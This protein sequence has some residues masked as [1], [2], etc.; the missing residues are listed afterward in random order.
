MSYAVADHGGD[1]FRGRIRTGVDRL[2]VPAVSGV[3]GFAEDGDE[4]IA[5][6]VG[7][8]A[9]RNI[10]LLVRRVAIGRQRELRKSRVADSVSQI[11]SAVGSFVR[12]EPGARSVPAQRS[13]GIDFSLATRSTNAAIV[14]AYRGSLPAAWPAFGTSSADFSPRRSFQ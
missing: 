12:H 3:H 13:S 1:V 5:G 4:A 10:A 14:G 8:A 9:F 11:V 2:N 6:G 7:E